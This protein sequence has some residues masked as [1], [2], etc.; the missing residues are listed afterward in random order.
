M[1]LIH[2][3][4]RGW[5][6]RATLQ[7]GAGGDGRSRSPAQHAAHTNTHTP[8]PFL[9]RAAHARLR[10]LAFLQS[11]RLPTAEATL[12]CSPLVPPVLARALAGGAAAAAGGDVTARRARRT[13]VGAAQVRPCRSLSSRLPPPHATASGFSAAASWPPGLSFA[14]QTPSSA[15]A[16]PPRP[17]R[18]ARDPRRRHNTRQPARRR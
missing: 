3:G 17:R 4:G 18:V 2:C 6:A 11:Q 15:S 12:P 1:I 7:M 13:D 5:N 8:R 10:S 9:R 16:S 14:L